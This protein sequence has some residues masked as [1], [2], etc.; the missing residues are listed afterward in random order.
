MKKHFLRCLVL[1]LILITVL[2]SCQKDKA[3]CDVANP[4]K[5]LPWLKEIVKER[6]NLPS[7]NNKAHLSIYK[8]TYNDGIDGI[9]VHYLDIPSI[10]IV[11]PLYSC[12][13]TALCDIGLPEAEEWNIKDKRLI[14]TNAK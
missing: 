12:D 4:V 11:A 7:R 3:C 6:H 8:C 10:R 2:F 5:D 14:W 9:I 13:G 1:V